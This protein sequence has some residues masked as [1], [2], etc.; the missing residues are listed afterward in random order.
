M[1]SR[2]AS[3]SAAIFNISRYAIHDGPGIRV[4]FFLCGCPLRCWWCHN[5]ES[6]LLPAASTDAAVRHM[7][8][9]EVVAE[10]EKEI[11]F[12]DESGGGVTFSGGEPLMQFEFL[13]D[14]LDLCQRREIHTAVDT[15][16]YA[17]PER[18]RQIAE[19]ANLFLY[20]LKLMNDAAHQEYTG[21]SNQLVLS[22][23]RM[24]A[25][26][27]KPT[28]IR[29]PVIPG[30]TDTR[31]N[32]E[33]MLA[34]LAGLSNLRDICLLPYHATAAGKYE[35]L[36]MHNRMID[37]VSPSPEAMESLRL[38]FHNQGYHVKIGG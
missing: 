33:A 36:G 19:R 8:P 37:T 38:F 12:I 11:I 10:I 30:V 22:N 25:D 1:N 28:I 14:V 4:T 35:R 2:P 9:R 24:L 26:M 3:P 27:Q 17:K 7:S 21:V 13:R 23:L 31:E 5:P 29:F 32:V 20:D 6:F 18:F 15:T 16:G 34:F